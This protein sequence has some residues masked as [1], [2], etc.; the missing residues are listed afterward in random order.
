MQVVGATNS[1]FPITVRAGG[2]HQFMGPRFNPLLTLTQPSPRLPCISPHLA[3]NVLSHMHPQPTYTQT[4]RAL[5][6]Y[7]TQIQGPT[8]TPATPA[9]IGQP[10]GH[11]VLQLP[12][13]QTCHRPQIQGSTITPRLAASEV[14]LMKSIMA[15]CCAKDDDLLPDSCTRLARATAINATAADDLCWQ[16]PT[17][18]DAQ[19]RAAD[20]M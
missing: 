5:L 16:P 18:C 9:H 11:P 12:S 19:V 3:A 7:H 20:Y 2:R 10:T 1:V 15:Q 17:L 8:I 4:A 14:A 13:H 6:S